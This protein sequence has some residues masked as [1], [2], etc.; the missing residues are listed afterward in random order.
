MYLT[1]SQ[2]YTGEERRIT[3]KVGVRLRIV[4]LATPVVVPHSLEHM[5]T[6]RIKM[7]GTFQICITTMPLSGTT[8]KQSS[9]N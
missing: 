4:N 9:G 6:E 5:E 1:H 8:S 7:L 2:E 3:I